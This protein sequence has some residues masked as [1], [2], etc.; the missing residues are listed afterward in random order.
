MRIASKRC[1]ICRFAVFLSL[2]WIVFP[3][4]TAAQQF[5]S[6]DVVLLVDCSESAS[7]YLRPIAGILDRFVSGA[8]RGDS[9]F[10]YQFSSNPVLIAQGRVGSQGDI[11]RLKSQVFQL[12]S[13]GRYTNYSPAIERGLEQIRLSRAKDPSNDRLLVL[14]TDGRRDPN[15]T[16]SEK[17]T[18][19]QLLKRYSDLKAGQ[20]YSFYC[21]YLGDWFE[22][23]LQSYLVSAEA[24]FARWPENEQWLNELT[25]ADIRI[26][27]RSVFLGRIPDTPT[28]SSFSL[29]FYPRR[30]PR[31]LS[32]IELSIEAEFTEQTLDRFFDVSPRRVLSQQKPWSNTF[33]FETRGFGRGDYAG[34]FMF[35]PSEPQVLLL[36]PRIIDFSFSVRE[37]L[38]V[39]VPEPLLFG[40]TDFRGPYEETRM[41]SISP[42]GI[43]FPNR[44]DSVSVVAHIELPK[45]LELSIDPVLN[46]KQ[47]IVGI[48]LSR[49]QTLPRR[50]AGTYEGKI[51]LFSADGW[52][53]S[54]TEIPISVKVA[55][56]GISLRQIA[57]YV[58]VAVGCVL[59]VIA[60]LF[61]FGKVRRA[62]TDYLLHITHPVGKLI[63]TADPTRGIAKNINL[64]LLAKR[65]R[66]NEILVGMGV[67]GLDAELPHSSMMDKIYKFS[68]LKTADE[69]HTIIESVKGVDEVLINNQQRTGRV[70]LKHLDHV[71]L[72][73]FAF[74][75]EVP[76]LLH[77][78]V[79]YFLDAEIKQGWILSWKAESEGFHF[80]N[81]GPE[82]SRKQSFVRFY[83]LKAVAFVRDFDNELTK[84]LLS[85]KVPRSGHHVKLIFADEEEITGYVFDWRDP[86]DKFYFFP[87][88][89]GE[90]VL[91][92]LV[93]KHT[94]KDIVLHRQDA[95]AARRAQARFASIL[96][97]LK[98]EIGN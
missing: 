23:D 2:F 46:G 26:M 27:H 95:E 70:Q 10:C 69:V 75:Y 60:L 12:R 62:L 42:G 48:A 76:R 32:A 37:V 64:A 77:Q 7:P 72:G 33:A 88:S 18:F 38:R 43:D 67:E 28:H 90:N 22:K 86:G 49:H 45:G 65:K 78:V 71:K 80:L 8:R 82:P 53:F 51:R 74:R 29:S 57:S 84:H 47:I 21:F 97:K 14:I 34:A 31:Q 58:G 30:P 87:D 93:E 41:I 9:F 4:K 94:L 17:K 83:E 1:I 39:L 89:L 13:D 36:S 63:V 52:S 79:L 50:D 44:I 59:V 81:R 40:P 35:K 5:P 25:L 66:G 54:N 73:A 20:D 11:A 16:R 15:D 3:V 6:Q 91:F 92:F 96:E 61:A 24:H 68:G 19:E 98:R 55:R 56:S 85:L